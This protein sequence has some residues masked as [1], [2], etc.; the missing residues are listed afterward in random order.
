MDGLDEP[1]HTVRAVGVWTDTINGTHVRVA[2]PQPEMGEGIIA[3]GILTHLRVPRAYDEMLTMPDC[4]RVDRHITAECAPFPTNHMTPVSSI[5][6]VGTYQPTYYLLVGWPSYLFRPG[7]AVRAMRLISVAIGA[8]LLGSGML[9]ATRAGRGGA[10][11]IGAA[12]AATPMAIWIIGTINPSGLEIAAA[13][14]TWL[15]LL[16]LVRSGNQ[17][18]PTTV[19]R[20]SIA[21]MLFGLTRPL[22]PALVIFAIASV[23]FIAADRKQMRALARSRSVK[24]GGVSLFVSLAVSALWIIRNHSYDAFTGITDP[25]LTA[26]S[27]T[28]EHLTLMGFRLRQMIG[29][30]SNY[31][32]P[33]PDAF[34]WIWFGAVV[35]L[36]FGALLLGNLRQRI[37]T[38]GIVAVS[39]LVP[40]ISEVSK[41]RDYGFI[42]QGRYSLPFAIGVPILAAWTI[43]QHRCDHS[44]S[45]RHEELQRCFAVSTA[46]MVT[47]T[48]V[49]SYLAFMTRMS[50]GY[51]NPLF[52]YLVDANWHPPISAILLLTLILIGSVAYGAFIIAMTVP[53]RFSG[54]RPIGVR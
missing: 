44:T 23:M 20:V 51:P 9:S 16:E 11:V 3:T 5:T 41:A 17:I 12:L 4:F 32:S 29:M 34:V 15:G 53:N 1:A 26:S 46:V 19:F 7:L 31:E 13:F 14:A 50:I 2:T 48:M 8:A 37:A 45:N 39:I 42:W 54:S 25:A 21:A 27:I 43:A 24:V 28:R 22:S 47:T 36:I 40:L 10:L 52:K 18:S 6:Y 30:F 35:V 49:V 33:I 38:V